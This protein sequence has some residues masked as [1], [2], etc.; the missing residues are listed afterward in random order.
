MKNKAVYP[1]SFDPITNGHID[2]IY[3]A[4]KIFDSLTVAILI[5]PKKTPLFSI[6]EREEMIKEVFKN[7]PRI[8]VKGFSGLLVD[9]MQKEKANVVIRGLRAVSD[10]ELEFQMAL[11]NRK[12]YPDFET[13]FM[14]PGINYTFLNSTVVKEIYRFGGRAPELVPEIVEKYLIKKFSES[15]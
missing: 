1:G 11:T 4:L 6:E 14:V 13:F 15:Q 2:L 3:R 5:N 8:N 7:E 12:L 9:F 10:F